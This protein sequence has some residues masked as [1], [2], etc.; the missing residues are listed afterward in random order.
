M[1]AICQK[2]GMFAARPVHA[3]TVRKR[4]LL[5]YCKQDD[6]YCVFPWQCNI[7]WVWWVERRSWVQVFYNEVTLDESLFCVW[8][9]YYVRKLQEE[10]SSLA[11]IQYQH[12]VTAPN[13][14]IWVAIGYATHRS[15]VRIEVILTPIG[16]YLTPYI[17][18]LSLVFEIY[19]TPSSKEKHMSQV[20]S[21][22]PWYTGFILWLPRSLKLLLIENIWSWIVES[23]DHFSSQPMKVDKVW[24][25]IVAAWNELPD[26]TILIC[27][28]L[29]HVGS[30]EYYCSLIVRNLGSRAVNQST[31]MICFVIKCASPSSFSLSP[32]SSLSWQKGIIVLCANYKRQTS[33]RTHSKYSHN[34]L[35]IHKIHY[36]FM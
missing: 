32:Q 22:H 24:L 31:L 10:C 28:V 27:N 30:H 34:I 1:T 14:M 21:D 5:L 18:W 20:C 26:S 13:V 33:T 11:C 35:N 6:H 17:P 2:M 25:R 19:Q 7:A 23:L 29:K 36:N 9:P 4:F 16:T 8:W 15:L 12:R 3:R